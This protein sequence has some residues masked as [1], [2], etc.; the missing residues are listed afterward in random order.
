MGD[1][2]S[3]A[4]AERLKAEQETARSAAASWGA[5]SLP[6]LPPSLSSSIASIPR[7]L[8]LCFQRRSPGRG[9]LGQPP[10]LGLT[11]SLL[12][13]GGS[14]LSGQA[15]R[16]CITGR[17]ALGLAGIAGVADCLQGVLSVQH[18]W[19]SL[20]RTEPLEHGFFGG[21]GRAQTIA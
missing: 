10:F 3:A 21:S 18:G 4:E 6:N 12:S 20:L 9:L 13:R 5:A 16:L 1:A 14:L 17:L 2:N 7:G 11:G 19:V 15:R 8:L